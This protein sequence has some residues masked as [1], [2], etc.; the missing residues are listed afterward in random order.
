VDVSGLYVT[1]GLVDIDVHVY[2]GLVKDSDAGSSGWR[3]FA[4]FK[5]IFDTALLKVIHS[6]RLTFLKNA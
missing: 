2:P 3:N 4:D 6:L 1:P 5:P